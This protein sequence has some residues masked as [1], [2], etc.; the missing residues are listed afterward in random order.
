M[1][2]LGIETS[3]DETSLG[4]Y[5]QR[6]LKHW[7]SSQSIH[8]DYGGVVPEIASREHVQVLKSLYKNIDL[9]SIELIAVTVK[10]GLL[11]PLLTGMNFAKS[12]SLFYKIPLIGIDHLKAHLEVI[13]YEE[14][15]AYPYLGVLIS[16]GN[17][18]FYEVNS[19]FDFKLLEKTSDD[20]IGEAF[21][22]GGKILGLGYPAGHLVDQYARQGN[23][24]KINFN[25]PKNQLSFSG[26]KTALSLL[27][28]EKYS[29]ED[30]CASYE[31]ALIDHLL[32]RLK[33]YS[34][35]RIVLGGGVAL[36]TY[37]RSS[38]KNAFFV[39]KEYCTD[40]GAMIAYLGYLQ[41]RNKVFFPKS[42]K[43]NQANLS[44]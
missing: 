10:P 39:N 25:Y 13:H 8:Y 27:N 37:L 19:P 18:C 32:F 28:Q 23:A 12:L 1:T 3:C 7:T 20:A 30:I 4:L 6:I 21:D 31:K 36:N 34:Y 29:L 40:N 42:L 15:V 16:G 22:K 17:T 35:E 43:I 9:K 24:K 44:N 14:K 41:E 11:G 38:L 5:H 2:V 26:L 33:D